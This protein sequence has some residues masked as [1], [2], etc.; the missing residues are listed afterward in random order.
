MNDCKKSIHVGDVGIGFNRL[1][2]DYFFTEIDNYNQSEGEHK[3]IAGNHDNIKVM[4]N[5]KNFIDN[6]TM[7]DKFFCVGGAYSIDK[8]LRTEDADWWSHEE[9]T[10]IEW[11]LVLDRYEKIKPDYVVSHDCPWSIV[12]SMFMPKYLIPSITSQGLNAMFEIH[13]P[14]LWVFGHWHLTRIETILDTKFVCIGM[15]KAID[16]NL[17]TLETK[18][19]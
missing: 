18:V 1:M 17:D 9:M 3:F 15:E 19:L 7:Y 4:R 16:I 13:R 8:D 2:D 10:Q 12:S 5:N 6:G 11:N 14:K